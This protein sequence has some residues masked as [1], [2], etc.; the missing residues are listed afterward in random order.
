MDDLCTNLIHSAQFI[1]T[2]GDK[3][4]LICLVV[5]GVGR[6]QP[7]WILWTMPGKVYGIFQLPKKSKEQCDFS[8]FDLFKK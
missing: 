2:S 6:C 7:Q 3:T 5:A 8:I 4:E 1:S